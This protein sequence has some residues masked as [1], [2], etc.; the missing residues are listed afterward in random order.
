MPGITQQVNGGDGVFN[1][2]VCVLSPSILCSAFIQQIFIEL[3]LCIRCCSIYP[4]GPAVRKHKNLCS[5]GAYILEGRQQKNQDNIVLLHAVKC[6]GE[7]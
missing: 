1:S 3:L 7:K 6:I 2:K 4:G 5:Q